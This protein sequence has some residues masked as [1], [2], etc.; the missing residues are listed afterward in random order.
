MEKNSHN[1]ANVSAQPMQ[2]SPPAGMEKST[3]DS[4]NDLGQSTSVPS[5]PPP[6]HQPTVGR[7][8]LYH[9]PKA[10][11]HKGIKLPNGMKVAPAIVTQVFGENSAI[12]LSVFVC[13]PQHTAPV[14]TAWSIPHESSAME[15]QAYWSWPTRV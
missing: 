7:I 15:G 12:N 11:G 4:A 3:P 1:S 14:V 8:V 6:F 9:P 10:G 5:T 13:D 2:A